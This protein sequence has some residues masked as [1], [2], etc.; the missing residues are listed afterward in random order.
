[1]KTR[2]IAMTLVLASTLGLFG[3]AAAMR[4]PVQETDGVVPENFIGA[5][6][7]GFLSGAS[8]SSEEL[9]NLAATDEDGNATFQIVYNIDSSQRVQEQCEALA[10]DVYDAT[11][12]VVPVVD[13]MAKERPYEIMVGDA[14][15]LDTI[16]KINELDDAME[17][18]DFAICVI[19]TRVVIYARSDAALMSGVLFFMDQ[20]VH[21]S[22]MQKIYGIEKDCFF[23]Y[24]PNET[25]A[26]EL[27]ESADDRC[28]DFK[29]ESGL[30]MYTY[31]RLTYTGNQGWRIQTKYREAED[32]RAA[33]ASQILAYSL[34]EHTLGA[35]D[36]RFR[37]EDVATSKTQSTLTVTSEDGS[38]VE[39]NLSAFQM[40]FYAK[41]GTTPSATITNLTHNAGNSS[42]VGTLNE[43]EAIFGTG[44]RFN[45]VNQ[46]GKMLEM[47]SK[48][49]W[50]SK[51]ANYVVIP[52]LCLS[53]G[54]G[55]FLNSYEH[56]MLDLDV[57]RNN[58]WSA[59]LTGAPLDCYVF[60]TTE[61]ADVIYGYSSL[62][63]FAD[64]PE[65]WTYGMLVNSQGRDFSAR[66]TS[67]IEQLSPD[68]KRVAGLGEGVYDMIAKM[69]EYDL[70]WTGVV[71]EPWG[72]YNATKNHE[73]LKE[74]CDYVHSLGKKLMVYFTM[75]SAHSGM[76]GYNS[77]YLLTQ[78]RADGTVSYNLPN[79]TK[80][81]NNP[82]AE[83]GG[84]T[85]VYVDIT[86]PD[87]VEWFFG[88]YWDYLSNEIGVDGCKIDFCEQL[89]ENY[90][91]NYFDENI[92]T[93]GSHHW[94][95][96]AFHNKF[97]DMISS[98]PDSGL[99]FTRGGGIGMQRAPIMWAGDQV[100][101][102]DGIAWQLKA[103]LSS[104]LSG[105]PFM[106]YDMSGY[107]YGGNNNYK[108]VDYESK[109]F[110]R[111]VQYSAFAPFV[112]S[113]GKVKRAYRFAE[114]KGYEYVTEVY[115]AYTKLH[116][117]LTPYITETCRASTETGLPV[118]RH[119]ALGWQSDENVWNIDD[120]Y[121][122][123]DAFLVAPI[124]ADTTTRQVYLPE[125]TWKDLNTGTTY[126]VGAEGK[127]ISVNASLAEIPTFYNVNTTSE[128]AEELLDGIEE[129]Y[130]Y[131]RSVLP[132]A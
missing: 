66:W 46:R 3:C 104:G 89:P 55:I 36:E 53:R 26:V 27:L 94:Y 70:P 123:G 75:G 103:V 1:M 93:G 21:R 62:S 29:L 105:L 126:N 2:L 71:A 24:H 14:A 69:E 52:L 42:I 63:G 60:T 7:D 106:S 22:D 10:A 58:T 4:T 121:M 33:G 37:I 132:T 68:E 119:L 87:V 8:E 6:E 82:D 15:R 120:E 39:I 85:R 115:R 84:A 98:K 41:D 65:E 50:N 97:W 91:L 108:K 112:Q 49:H 32:F 125:G 124:L 31:V 25:P 57:T 92:P 77:V 5:N 61:I 101:F 72:N 102:W 79:T 76:K 48:D 107:Q 86:N 117:H 9:I 47:F 88:D 130:D 11:G 35:E 17:E 90:E 45:N 118:M 64:M 110:L 44:E 113:M 100:R 83:S 16:D 129:L 116:E 18:T 67:E 128:T 43:K 95:P 127:T 99:C 23:I 81:S 78:T 59:T 114:H 51:D 30:S 109:V 122:F 38:R 56:M 111:G 13:S 131:A 96:T 20:L 19:D 73:Q 28:V 34:G 54:S 80:N 12:I 40:D 74:L